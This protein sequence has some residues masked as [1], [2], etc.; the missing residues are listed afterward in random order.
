M[1]L[2]P[3]LF[4]TNYGYLPKGDRDY[5]FDYIKTDWL[6]VNTTAPAVTLTIEGPQESK[7]KS[8]SNMVALCIAFGTMKG[9]EIEPVKYIGG[10]KVLAVE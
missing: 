2:V 9:Q 3:D 8:C 10:A 5:I 1:G 7:P 6:P 4:Y